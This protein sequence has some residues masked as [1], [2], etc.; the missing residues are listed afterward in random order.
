MRITLKI[1]TYMAVGFVILGIVGYFWL[2]TSLPTVSGDL[3]V[4]GLEQPVSVYRDRNAVPHI[5]AGSKRDAYFALGF[6]HAQDR[7]WQMEFLRRL[8]AGRLAEVLGP[9]VVRTDKFIRT[10]GL[11]RA[12]EEIF[13]NSNADVQAAL[14]AYADGVNAWLA[15]RSGALPPEFALLRYE[16][17]PWR[18]A[19][20]LLWSRL[21]ATRLGRNQASETMRLRVAE[22]LAENGLPAE[23]IEEL[24][25]QAGVAE[26]T[27]IASSALVPKPDWLQDSGSNGWVLHGD[28]TTTGKPILANDPHLRFG[29]PILWYL[30]HIEAPGLRLTGATVPGVPFMVLGHNGKIAWGMANGGGD[31]EDIFVE[32]VD[33]ND[34]EKYLTPEGPQPFRKRREIIK[35]KGDDPVEITV[36]ETRHGP[37]V[38]DLLSTP[39]ADGRVAAL[40]TPAVRG[41]DSTVAALKAINES[42]H[43]RDFEAAARLFHTPHTNLF[44]ASTAGD[45]GLVSAG[46]IPVRKAGTGFAPVR[47]DDGVHDWSGFI[48]TEDLPRR[49]NPSSGWIVNA[50]NRVVGDDY[51]YLIT[52]DW[53]PPYRAE[54]I[55]E[56][57]KKRD[58]HDIDASEALQGD[59]VSAAAR[60]LLPLMLAAPASAAREKE[61]LS[62]LREWNYEMSRDRPEPLIYATWLRHLGRELI[63]DEIS[64]P[65]ARAYQRLLNRPGARFVHTVLTVK[66]HWCNDISTPE[67]ESCSDLLA[68]TLGLALDELEARFGDDWSEW[69]WGEV[70]RAAFSHPVLTHSPL[71]ARFANLNIESDGGD[72]TVS[73]GMT[74]G[75]GRISPETHLDGAGYRAVY[76]LADLDNS[77]F[78]IATGQSGNLFSPNYDDFL[79]RWRDGKYIRIVGGQKFLRDGGGTLLSLKPN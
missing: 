43:W 3:I 64:G 21:M 27:S 67:A 47:G 49:H 9:Q 32:T 10:L 5:F 46:R 30:A 75:Q 26:P 77:R 73:R 8:G 48:P 79:E 22:A 1:F 40:A 28:R 57:L 12:A 4:P 41:D 39:R 50:N 18:P 53:G 6:V 71:A 66:Q 55:I 69:R 68:E 29:A 65:K 23:L 37:V 52:R 44:F 13:A 58:Q 54:R 11:P 15:G 78:M 35:V 25:P 19:D 34:P 74:A 60:K 72:Y 31:V 17:E 62:A 42:K 70:H 38:S 16:P 59:T 24:W 45:V 56:F 14:K 61:A 2:K 20:P 76:D 51:P 33:P 36:R 7:L 63:S